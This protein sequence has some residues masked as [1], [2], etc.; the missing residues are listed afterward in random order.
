MNNIGKT[1]LKLIDA[2]P[3]SFINDNDEFIAHEYSNQYICLGN[4]ETELDIK[5][6]VLEW[7]SRPA[8]KTAPYHQEWRNKR[9]NEFMLAG[10]N[11][12]LGTNFTEQ[13]ISDIYDELGNAINHKLTVNFVNSGYDFN[14]LREANHE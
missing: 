7:F 14:V 1:W 5:C 11:K 9:F 6:K 4:C 3:D 2:F 12:F 8:H 13:E 10:V